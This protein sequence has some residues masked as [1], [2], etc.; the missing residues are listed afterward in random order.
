M[1]VTTPAGTP[2]SPLGLAA[3]PK[4]DPRC[5][6]RAFEAGINYYFFYSL[7]ARDFI[8][9]L[10]PLLAKHRDEVIVGSGSGARKR[11]SLRAVRKKLLAA[12]GGGMLDIFFAEYV[13][14]SDDPEAI[15]GKGGALDELSAWKADGVIRYVGATAH[16][17]TIARQLAADP[18]VDVLMHRY[19]MAH[20]KAARE[21]FPTALETNT[22]VVAFT[23]TRWGTL[24]KPQDGWTAN[25]PVAADC[26]RFCLAQP[27]VQVVLT[28]P[29]TVGELADN[30]AVVSSPPMGA[31]ELAEWERFGDVVY[32]QGRDRFETEWP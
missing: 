27:A 28:A 2:A 15:F 8:E 19:N 30:V 16:D 31:A 10:Q 26:Y 12:V 9:G 14:P 4:Q 24:M 20:R 3:Y 22:P 32:G 1:I 23:A 5:I 18:R 17:R 11:P 25:P 29:K 6:A 7:G 13:N 21:V